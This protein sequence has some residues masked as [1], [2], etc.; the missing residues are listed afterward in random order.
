MKALVIGDIHI[1]SDNLQQVE[2]LL[3]K[4]IKIIKNHNIDTIILLGDILHYHERVNIQC[5]NKACLFI[6][7]LESYIEGNIYIIVGNHD[8]IDSNQYLSTQHWLVPLKEWNGIEICDNVLS[9]EDNSIIFCP[10]VQK[11]KFIEALNN[12]PDWKEARI[13]FA[14]QE[15][16]GCVYGGKIST[17]DDVWLENYPQLIS[18]HIHLNQKYKNI[19]YLGSVQQISHSQD[20]G[21]KCAVC[22]IDTNSDSINIEEIELDMPR[23]ITLNLIPSDLEKFNHT[24]DNSVRIIISGSLE[25][26]KSIKKS[27]KYLK[28]IKQGVKVVFKNDIT[29][30]K[31]NKKC[32]KFIDILRNL[33]VAENNNYLTELFN[34]SLK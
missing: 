18:G 5:M 27:Q 21:E 1:K 32:N 26:C 6:K 29:T 25:E 15:V 22:I 24:S 14:H 33:I 28:L 19:Y 30:V 4:L 2:L 8:M 20:E 23:K 7:K 11:G 31:Q 13:I 12:I 16:R 10:Y 17:S 34:F 9:I 3:I